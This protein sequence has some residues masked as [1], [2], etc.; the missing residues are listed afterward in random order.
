MHNS[1]NISGLTRIF[2]VTSSKMEVTKKTWS[3]RIKETK[4]RLKRKIWESLYLDKD[5]QELLKDFEI[6]LQQS[7]VTSSFEDIT[8]SKLNFQ[9]KTK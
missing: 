9:S 7:L 2:S 6:S 4:K 3:R 5:G 1:Q 8:N